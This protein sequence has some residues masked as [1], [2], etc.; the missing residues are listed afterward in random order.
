MYTYISTYFTKNN[1]LNFLLCLIPASFVAGNMILNINILFLLISTIFVY[2]LE[3]LKINFHFIDKLVLLFFLFIL[4]SGFFNTIQNY[5]NDYKNLNVLIKSISYL[6]YLLFYLVIRFLIEKNIINYK[7]F[8]LSAS[9][10]P[11]LVAFDIFIQFYFGKDIFGFEPIGRRF[12]G[13]FNDELIAGGYLQRFSLFS[14][15]FISIFYKTNK[16]FLNIL[17]VLTYLIFLISILLS[18]NRMPLVLFIFI[19]F[20]L[21]LFRKDNLKYLSLLILIFCTIIYVSIK[22]DKIFKKYDGP[23]YQNL[24]SFIS[25]VDKLSLIFTPEKIVREEMPERFREFE[26]FYDTWLMNKYIGGGLK[27][28]RII[29][30]KRENIDLQY[31]ERD[32]CNT[33]PHNY[34][35]EILADLGMIG[36]LILSTIF[37][38]ILYFYFKKKNFYKNIDNNVSIPFFLLFIAEIFPIKS[39][40]SFFTTGNSTY[41]F[42]ILAFV[43]AFNLSKKIR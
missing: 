36:L 42:M 22:N 25:E 2:R 39:T 37:L 34:Y 14:I 5:N 4:F 7:Y 29:C 15:F 40:G 13:P 30:P 19:S 38:L 41:I 23:I 32:T 27:S 1:Y 26:T 10:F 9:I 21:L 20:L 17:I 35:L 3:V 11:I 28:F 18:G 8:F 33:H 16:N 43:V 12:A 31:G 6:R 24:H